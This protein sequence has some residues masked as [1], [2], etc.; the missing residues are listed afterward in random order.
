MRLKTKLIIG[1]GFLFIVI[2][3]FGILSIASINRL[4][5]NSEKVLKN[6]YETLVYN[7]NMLEALNKLPADTSA[8]KVFEDNLLLQQVNVTEPGEGPAT[9]ELTSA[10]NTYKAN[11]GDSLSHNIILKNIQVINQLNQQA[12]LQKNE[13]AMNAADTANTWLTLIFTVLALIAFTLVVNFPS[14]ISGPIQTLSEGIGA[15]AGKDYKKRIHLK[16]KDE[17]GDLAN[18]FNLMAEKLDEYEH[19]NLA[20][21]KFEKS[22]IETIINKMNDAIIGFDEKRNILFMNA[23]A[24]SLLN[25][26]EKDV[27]GK[28]ASDVAL[29]N[30]LMRRL[31]QNGDEDELK[32]YADRKESYFS[33]EKIIVKNEEQVIGE[34]IVLQNITPFHELDEAKTNFIA[35]IS[36]ELKTPISSILMSAKL[37]EDAR[38]GVV[39]EEQKSLV[40]HIKEDSE[41]LLKITGE[42]LNLTQ[43]EAGKIQLAFQ[44]VLPKEILLYAIGANKTQA[45]QQ[46]QT[47]EMRIDPL[48]EAVNADKEKTSWVLTNL[49]ANAIRY[50][51]ED[52]RIIVSA[53]RKDKTVIF[54]VQDFG[55]GI[56]SNYKDKIFDRYFRVPGNKEEGTGLG[57]AICREFIEAQGGKIWVESDYGDGSKF[58][59][60]LPVA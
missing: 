11:P 43:V 35:T 18:A 27:V 44:P 51:F 37:L 17:F 50:S 6:N 47:I 42:L 36:H 12:I 57:L 55:K 59:F 24:E 30:D 31:L 49:V 3:V 10:F 32:I 22:R 34:V 19:S 26:K 7:N 20:K 54:S 4:K 41:R 23:V 39:N 1:L 52:S 53:E 40:Q 48:V 56:D 33:K 5:N 14:V 2:L 46:K 28:Y 29:K 58:S 60:W 8:W 45:E 21:I 25:L 15:I 13:L 9:A 16:Q 38:V